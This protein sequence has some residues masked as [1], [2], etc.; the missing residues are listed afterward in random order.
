M[1][2]KEIR[3]RNDQ[4]NSG[5]YSSTEY[6][7]PDGKSIFHR[8][9]RNYWGNLIEEDTYDENLVKSSDYDYSD[10]DMEDDHDGYYNND[11]YL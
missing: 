9:R 1:K 3:K 7:I 4:A 10:L 2:N 6:P 8:P 11:H 5:F